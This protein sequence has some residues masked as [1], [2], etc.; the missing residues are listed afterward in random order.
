MAKK[1]VIE[2]R[3]IEEKEATALGLFLGSLLKLIFIFLKFLFVVLYKISIFFGLWLPALYALFGV[4]MHFATGFDPFAGGL[5]AN[6][7][8]SGFTLCMVFAVIT[9]G[10]H[11]FLKPFRGVKTGFANPVWKRTKTNTDTPKATNSTESNAQSNSPA[12]ENQPTTTNTTYP[13]QH[14]NRYVDPNA[15]VP[16]VYPPTQN[17]YQAQTQTQSEVPQIYF[18]KR[19]PSL[20]VHE[21]KDRFETFRIIN[22]KPIK[23]KVEYK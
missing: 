11:I 3:V 18:S 14:T 1:R 23:D 17:A 7:Y 19:E 15:Y 10:W 6:L 9:S 21:Y 8:I 16:P 2:E 13:Y 5:Y 22:G 4:I 20:L 12:I